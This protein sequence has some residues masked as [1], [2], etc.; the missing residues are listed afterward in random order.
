MKKLTLHIEPSSQIRSIDLENILKGIRFICENQLSSVEGAD[1][2]NYT[3][4]V[5]IS[6]V[7]KGSIII[8]M[9]I[10]VNV[11]ININNIEWIP[12]ITS[13]LTGVFSDDVQGILKRARDFIR[14]A[15]RKG[16][17]VTIEDS[18]H[19]TIIV[20]STTDVTISN[21]KNVKYVVVD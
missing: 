8:E 17:K 14:S 12:V 19:C 1:K 18:E 2:R 9:M 7:D 4:K 15:V 21:S 16:N 3:D 5:L 13:I 11:N 20:P 6:G 10:N